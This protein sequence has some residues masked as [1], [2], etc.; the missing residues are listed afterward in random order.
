MSAVGL[1]QTSSQQNFFRFLQWLSPDIDEAGRRHNEIHASLMRVFASRG[2]DRPEELADETLERVVRKI[3]V[4]APGYQG[5]PAA[6]V[7]GVGKRVFWGYARSRRIPA[8]CA[9]ERLIARPVAD[10]E[11]ERRYACLESCLNELSADD[12]AL[13]LQYYCGERSGKAEN[14]QRLAQDSQVSQQVL[15]KRTQ[16]IRERLKAT[17]IERLAEPNVT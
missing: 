3:D 4:V 7:Y 1:T 15:R 11:L 13:I 8:R 9:P 16:R 14:R 12:R 5:N 17:L 10:P 2:C 6:Y